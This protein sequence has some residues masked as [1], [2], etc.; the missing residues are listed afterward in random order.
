MVKSEAEKAY[1]DAKEILKRMRN[2]RYQG[3]IGEELIGLRELLKDIFEVYEP[4]S[5]IV[6]G[7]IVHEQGVAHQNLG[8][9]PQALDCLWS[10]ANLRKGLKYSIDLFYTLHQIVMCKLARGDSVWDV[11]EDIQQARKVFQFAYEHA[12]GMKDFQ[13]RGYISHN[14][15]FYFQLAREFEN[16][17]EWYHESEKDFELIGDV[18][19]KALSFL[20]QA[21]CCKE[22]DGFGIALT[23]LDKVEGIFKKLGDEK[24]LNEIEKTRAE[25]KKVQ[26]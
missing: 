12:T 1:E 19:G 10:A 2:L 14:Y 18:R 5:N 20:R 15:A 26:G 8:D 6:H 13:A 9:Y 22:I 24:R 4:W 16:A 23:Y 3:K 21:Q 25:I 11:K 7:D 17:L